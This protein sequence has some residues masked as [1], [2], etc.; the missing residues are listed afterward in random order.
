[1][2]TLILM[3]L[4][5]QRK[6][7]L[8]NMNRMPPDIDASKEA[9]LSEKQIFANEHLRVLEV[10]VPP[11]VKELH[12]QAEKAGFFVVGGQ[13]VIWQDGPVIIRGEAI[14]VEFSKRLL[15]S[16]VEAKEGVVFANSLVKVT[17]MT[18]GEGARV[19]WLASEK[20]LVLRGLGKDRSGALRVEVK[21]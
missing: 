15:A 11:G 17:K 4:L 5:A 1:M 14:H 16:S 8:P 7:Q 2:K 12:F 21:F 20:V 9:R 6:E 3:A 18:K 19:E 10:K 13:R